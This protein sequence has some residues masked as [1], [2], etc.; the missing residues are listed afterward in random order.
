MLLLHE[1]PKINESRI[2]AHTCI[3]FVSAFWDR[4]IQFPQVSYFSMYSFSLESSSVDHGPLFT[5]ASS[6]QGVVPISLS[7]QQL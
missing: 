7:L 2:I 1:N 3:Y 6:Q 5:F 4:P